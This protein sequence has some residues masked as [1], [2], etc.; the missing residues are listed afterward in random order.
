MTVYTAKLSSAEIDRWI[1]HARLAPYLHVAGA[2]DPDLAARLY[3]SNARLASAFM[4]TIHHVEVLVRNA[5]DRQLAVSQPPDGLRSWLVDPD[6][7]QPGE[8]RAVQGAIVRIRRLG[9]SATTHRVI[10]GLPLSFW[11]RLTGT[12][13]E[14][15]WKASIHRAFPHSSGL[16]KDVAGPLNR[17]SQMRNDIAHHQSLIEVPVEARHRDLLHLAAAVDPAAASWIAA[18]SRVNEVLATMPAPA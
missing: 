11:A 9:K 15:L 7:L 5:I 10:A 2:A 18:L 4:E 8:L 13:Y 12:G 17:V 3:V 16:R 14:E 1:T 6:V